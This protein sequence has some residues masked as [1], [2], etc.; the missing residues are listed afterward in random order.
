MTFT[1]YPAIDVRDGR[2]VRLRQ[3]DYD[4]QTAYASTPLRAALDHAAHGAQW[5]HLVDL[6][7]ARTGGY[8]LLPW[9]EKSFPPLRCR[10]R[11]AAACAA[12]PTS[13]RCWRQAR[14]GS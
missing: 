13:R 4:A 5:L 12:K 3:G 2:V 14:P 7:A 8:T 1:V 10:S 6:D 11:P 9:C